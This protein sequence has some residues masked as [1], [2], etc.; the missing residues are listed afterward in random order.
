M[1][2]DICFGFVKRI[3]G[4]APLRCSCCRDDKCERLTTVEL[5]RGSDTTEP[6]TLWIGLCPDCAKRFEHADEARG[7]SGGRLISWASPRQRR[8]AVCLILF[9]ASL[10]SEDGL[11]AAYGGAF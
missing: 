6:G 3:E 2:E 5:G 8:P 1:T 7:R 9:T 4:D 10:L 11:R